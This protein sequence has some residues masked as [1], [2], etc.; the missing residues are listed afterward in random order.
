MSQTAS[1]PA[2]PATS[3]PSTWRGLTVDLYRSDYRSD[4][5]VWNREGGPDSVT[6]VAIRDE[7]QGGGAP[8]MPL[9]ASLHAPS[10]PSPRQPAAVLV[11]RHV[12]RM[13]F[14]IEPLTSPEQGRTPFMAG[15]SYAG[16]SDSRFGDLI[17]FYGAVKVHDFSETWA[18]YNANFD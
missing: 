3:D 7:R 2:A 18:Q 8:L 14:H 5:C 16:S 17:N 4:N 10:T 1:N 6:L 12:G 9:P 15:G 13:V 11:V